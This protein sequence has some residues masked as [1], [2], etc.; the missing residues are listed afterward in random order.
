VAY[1]T[2]PSAGAQPTGRGRL[3]VH[4][5]TIELQRNFCKQISAESYL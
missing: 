4:G 3:C 1:W 2:V 5:F